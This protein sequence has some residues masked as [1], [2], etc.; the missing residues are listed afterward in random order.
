MHD[1]LPI[2]ALMHGAIRLYEDPE[3]F[4]LVKDRTLYNETKQDRDTERL[5]GRVVR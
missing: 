4:G 2:D 5:R 3:T 1:Q